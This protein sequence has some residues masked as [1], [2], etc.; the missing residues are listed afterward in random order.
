MQQKWKTPSALAV[1][2]EDAPLNHQL[3]S[4]WMLDFGQTVMPS[5][6]L[7][8]RRAELTDAPTIWRVPSAT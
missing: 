3:T 2:L 4:S 7:I 1:D 5:G 6:M 8:L